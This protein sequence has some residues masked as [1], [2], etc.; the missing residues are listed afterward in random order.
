MAA[1]ATGRV[2]TQGLDG[3]EAKTE[4]FEM[5]RGGIQGLGSTAY[6]FILCL[7]EILEEEDALNNDLD[8]AI[9][10]ECLR[11]ETLEREEAEGGVVHER[12]LAPVTTQLTREAVVGSA[13]GGIGSVTST[14]PMLHQIA[15]PPPGTKHRDERLE[16][17]KRI[18]ENSATAAANGDF[19]AIAVHEPVD[20]NSDDYLDEGERR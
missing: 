18:L 16:V 14:R 20:Q 1:A 6:L 11:I 9:R 3:V 8:Y 5:T 7:S 17:L 12:W 19:D 13:A 15:E 4:P 10:R 2:R